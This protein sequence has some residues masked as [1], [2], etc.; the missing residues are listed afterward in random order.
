MNK[1]T[2]KLKQE[3]FI[4]RCNKLYNNYYDYSKVVYKNTRSKIIVICP[5]H[6]EFILK[7]SSHLGN[8]GCKKCGNN[9]I[10]LN[11][12]IAQSNKIHN[13]KYRYDNVVYINKK[14]KV[15]ITCL[16]HGDFLQKP[17][18]HLSGQGCPK[19]VGKKKTTEEIILE[20]KK[21]HGDTY[22]YSL[23]EYKGNKPK[24]KII[25]KKHGVFEQQVAI[26][27][28]KNGCIKCG[29]NTSIDGNNFI[30]SFN[31]DNI[32]IENIMKIGGQRFKVDGFDPTTNTIYEYFGSFWHG[33]PDRKD[34]IGLHPF[35]K[36]T[37][38]ELYQKTLNRIQH[39]KDNGYNIVYKWGR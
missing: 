28:Q 12:F 17:Q 25:C 9:M 37:Y 29:N 34:L 13:Y 20:F 6:G 24:V 16:K 33:H 23:V 5:K 2:K 35:Y 36:I 11:E 30:K 19:C 27:L 8:R 14:T 18:N 15:N 3:D 4:S 10:T 7:A 21:I 31:N 38:D 32:I 26:H 1:S 22:D 39:F